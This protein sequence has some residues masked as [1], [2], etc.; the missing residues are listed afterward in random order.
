MICGDV[1]TETERKFLVVGG[2][3]RTTTPRTIEQGYLVAEADV[4]IRVRI[5]DGRQ[6][7]LTVKGMAQG[8]AR[9]EIECGL[10]PLDA[11][12]ELVDTFAAGAVV[13]K[14]RHEIDVDGVVWEVDEF[15]GDNAG[16]VLAELEVPAGADPEAHFDRALHPGRRPFWL[17]SEVTGDRSYSNAA[18]ARRPF[19]TWLS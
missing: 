2:G 11:A 12:A 19:A 17:G 10:T 6:A 5:I 7:V 16:L 4:E 14:M 8:A 18:L 3:W 15:D 1:A 13:T 9:T